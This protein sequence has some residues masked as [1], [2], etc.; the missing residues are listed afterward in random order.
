MKIDQFNFKSHDMINNIHGK[1]YIPQAN[2][3]GIIQI[4]HGMCEYS[5]RYDEFSKFLS[6][7]GFIVIIQDNLGHGKSVN[8]PNDLG[9][10]FNVDGSTDMIEDIYTAYSIVKAKFNNL[11]YF[12]IGHGMGSFLVRS[13]ISYYVKDVTGAILI[14]T[15]AKTNLAIKTDLFFVKAIRLLRGPRYR[16]K[17]LN[18]MIL[19]NLNKKIDTPSQFSWLSV[20]PENVA[21]YEKDPL[22]NFIFTTNGFITLLNSILRCEDIAT[23]NNIPI[24]FPILLM[25]GQED[26]IGKYGK[27]VNKALKA[28]KDSGIIDVTLNLYEDD[29]HEI[30]NEIDRA[31]IYTDIYNWIINHIE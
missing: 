4:V 16:S 13:Y 6:L 14:G 28:Y 3:K 29:R 9:Y 2:I 1:I 24:K 23:I 15:G 7:N 25:S 5:D 8:N 21:K 31:V 10:Y 11:P 22:C 19:G 12:V 27:G 30:L 20:N 26:P 17:F 18:K